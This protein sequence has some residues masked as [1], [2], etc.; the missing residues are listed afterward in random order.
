MLCPAGL[1]R[2]PAFSGTFGRAYTCKIHLFPDE[3][4][5]LFFSSPAYPE[6]YTIQKFLNYLFYPNIFCLQFLFLNF[7]PLT[8]NIICSI[9][10]TTFRKSA[11]THIN[12]KG[13]L[14]HEKVSCFDSNVGNGSCPDR[15]RRRQRRLLRRCRFLQHERFCLRQRQRQLQLRLQFRLRRFHNNR[16][17]QT[18]HGHQRS[19]PSL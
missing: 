3:Y 10:L 5:P 4:S 13:D 2:S 11:G 9:L 15:L 17:G 7:Y 18:D 1:P 12:C 16:G 19:V 14:N 6:N 8:V